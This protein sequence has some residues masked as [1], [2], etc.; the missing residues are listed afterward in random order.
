MASLITSS[1]LRARRHFRQVLGLL[2]TVILL[3]I[4]ANNLTFQLI[5]SPK[6]IATA[7]MIY[8]W[9]R[10][11][12]PMI[13]GSA[14]PDNVAF[15]FSWVRDIYDPETAEKLTG[16]RFFNF[17]MSGATSFESLR[18]LQHALAVHRPKRVFLDLE[19]F[20]DTSRA[21]LVE[22]QFDER[23]LDVNRDGSRNQNAALQRAI[24]INTSGAALAFNLRFLEFLWKENQGIPREELLPSYQ[25]RDWQEYSGAA[26]EMR[27]WVEDY[28]PD[29]PPSKDKIPHTLNDLEAALDLLC[30][31]DTEIILVETAHICGRPEYMRNGLNLMRKLRPTC[32][33]PMSF[34]VFHYPNAVTMEAMSGVRLSNFYRPDGHPRPTLGQLMLTR[35]LVLEGQENAPPLPR[36]FGADL[37]KMSDAQADDWL[38]RKTNRCLG[39]WD[40]DEK[41][42]VLEDMRRLTPLWD[43]QF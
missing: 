38:T 16:E 1:R 24:K 39:Q 25:R 3:I 10:L 26:D 35:M 9:A 2:L 11:Y 31:T 14:K 15:G 42:E 40:A 19:S 27:G 8:G 5:K 29:F 43:T 28:R 18:V 22:H 30:E 7:Q 4:V 12:K 33:A 37:L 20:A 36:D 6:H 13:Y 17:G 41:T 23:I 21:S 32:K 34:F